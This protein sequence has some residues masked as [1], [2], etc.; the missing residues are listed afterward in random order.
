MDD[1]NHLF[2][3]HHE[4]KQKLQS[5]YEATQDPGP[6]ERD[7]L[8]NRRWTEEKGFNRGLAVLSKELDADGTA[9]DDVKAFSA[10]I[11]SVSRP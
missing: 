4:L 6:R 2:Q 10:Y 3:E 7:A 5:I 8:F 9:G 11:E 1:L